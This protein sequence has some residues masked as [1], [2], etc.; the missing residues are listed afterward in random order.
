MG[1]RA[2]SSESFRVI[3]SSELNF[4]SYGLPCI[5]V[6]RLSRLERLLQRIKIKTNLFRAPCA[7]NEVDYQEEV[8]KKVEDLLEEERGK[9][10]ET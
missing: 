10:N 4:S 2:L 6:D 9:K 7:E 8:E 5:G 1:R 3:Q